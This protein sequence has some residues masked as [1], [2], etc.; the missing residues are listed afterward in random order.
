MKIHGNDSDEVPS[1]GLSTLPIEGVRFSLSGSRL[2][3]LHHRV[4]RGVLLFKHYYKTSA[5][6]TEVLD[7]GFTIRYLRIRSV[8]GEASYFGI[9]FGKLASKIRLTSART[10]ERVKICRGASL[11]SGRIF[12]SLSRRLPL[13]RAFDAV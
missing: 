10:F 8:S 3:E 5:W 2:Y 1:I 12:S 4:R 11:I 7:E 13:N 9:M 6:I